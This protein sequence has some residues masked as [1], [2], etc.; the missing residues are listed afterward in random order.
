[1]ETANAKGSN[2]YDTG[3]YREANFWR[4]KDVILSYNLPSALLNKVGVDGIRIFVQAT[5]LATF[6]DWFRMDPEFETDPSI[7]EDVS[8]REDFLPLQ[9]EVAFGISVSF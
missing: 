1:M 9:K 7:G 6:T 2:P 4:L 8:D 3:F 5:N